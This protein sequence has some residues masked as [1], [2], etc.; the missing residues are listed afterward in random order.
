L[1]LPEA[2]YPCIQLQ[3]QSGALSGSVAIRRYKIYALR[4]NGE[5]FTCL[6]LP[7]SYMILTTTVVV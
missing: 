6:M 4:V 3:G 1:Y 2:N 5:E 7:R